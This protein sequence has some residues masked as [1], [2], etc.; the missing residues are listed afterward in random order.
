MGA[1]EQCRYPPWQDLTSVRIEGTLQFQLASEELAK[2]HKRD[3]GRE[4]I[5]DTLMVRVSEAMLK[6]PNLATM[7][8]ELNNGFR[9]AGTVDVGQLPLI[10]GFK[11]N[12]EEWLTEGT[13]PWPIFCMTDC[14][15][16]GYGPVDR[17][18]AEFDGHPVISG[19]R[20]KE[21]LSQEMRRV[22]ELE[23]WIFTRAKEPGTKEDP[24]FMAAL[25][26]MSPS[27]GPPPEGRRGPLAPLKCYPSHEFLALVQ[28]A[29]QHWYDWQAPEKVLGNWQTLLG[30]LRKREV[31]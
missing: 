10:K 2:D 5:F 20:P 27:R 8:L 19:Q 15:L 23:D 13:T 3:F 17:T 18:L 24:K 11:F 22:E 14:E 9:L 1:D 25:K 12:R 16:T 31:V 28:S 4:T 21:I 7:T 30:R 29:V 26:Q 6:M